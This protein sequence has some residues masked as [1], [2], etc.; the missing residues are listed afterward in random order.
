MPAARW[1][2]RRRP[3]T[4]T[5]CGNYRRHRRGLRRSCRNWR[6]ERESAPVSRVWRLLDTGAFSLA[7]LAN[8]SKRLLVL[9]SQVFVTKLIF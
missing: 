4:L 3:S 8:H 1:P 6:P 2:T 9:A 5:P 7:G